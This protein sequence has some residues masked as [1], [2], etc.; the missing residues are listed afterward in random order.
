MARAARCF[1]CPARR[2]RNGLCRACWPVWKQ[3]S[4]AAN[5]ARRA[6]NETPVPV[7]ATGFPG[8]RVLRRRARY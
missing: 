1:N 2:W 5:A 6:P 8:G 7:V 4:D 3:M